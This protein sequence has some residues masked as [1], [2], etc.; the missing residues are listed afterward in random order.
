MLTVCPREMVGFESWKGNVLKMLRGPLDNI[1]P[2]NASTST[3]G[4]SRPGSSA[5]TIRSGPAY[6]GSVSELA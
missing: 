6:G 5:T 3:F 1:L 2:S 4:L